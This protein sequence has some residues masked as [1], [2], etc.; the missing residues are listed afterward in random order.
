MIW[1]YYY[2]TEPGVLVERPP[3]GKKRSMSLLQD[4]RINDRY[5]VSRGAPA[6]AR[7]LIWQQ[8]LQ[9]N[10]QQ[11]EELKLSLQNSRMNKKVKV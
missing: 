6:R 3:D 5:S 2:V 7:L 9:S 10:L 4:A 11:S 8:N 1:A